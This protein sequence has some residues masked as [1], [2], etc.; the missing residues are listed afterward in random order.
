MSIVVTV[1]H[2]ALLS[3]SSVGLLGFVAFAVVNL[4]DLL[5]HVVIFRHFNL[6]YEGDNSVHCIVGHFLLCC[7]LPK[8][9]RLAALFSS[10]LSIFVAWVATSLV[11]T[12]SSK[13]SSVSESDA[14]SF[15]S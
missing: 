12:V 2:A 10:N 5:V 9:L 3:R 14:P 8:K 11:L 6:L 4:D 15:S 7:L 13:L 1:K